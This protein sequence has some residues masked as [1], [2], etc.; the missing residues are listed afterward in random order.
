MT[1]KIKNYI[2]VD[3]NSC[4]ERIEEREIKTTTGYK[5]IVKKDGLYILKDGI[6]FYI[7]DNPYI[8]INNKRY[9]IKEIV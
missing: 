9:Q 2:Y 3:M 8:L 6:K 7:E 4:L 1:S 5:L